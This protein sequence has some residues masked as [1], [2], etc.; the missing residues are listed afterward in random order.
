MKAL[1]HALRFP[2]VL[3]T[4]V[5]LAL[6]FGYVSWLDAGGAARLTAAELPSDGQPAAFEVELR[7]RPEAFHMTRLQAAG[8]LIRVEDRSV[9]LMDVRPE[10]AQ[11][12]A[13][14][15]WVADVRPWAGL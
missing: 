2:P 14:N 7:F 11:V 5:V 13:R 1:L 4:L 6:W 9:F 12:I 8:R 10:A 15:Y 3:T